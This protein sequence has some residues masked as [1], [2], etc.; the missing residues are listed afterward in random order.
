MPTMRLVASVNAVSNGTYVLTSDTDNMY[1]NVDSTTYGTVTHNRASTNNTYYFYLR[2][3]NFDDIPSDA[4]VSNWTVKIKA[5]A[6][7][8]TTSTSSSY[9]MSLCQGTTSIG[10]T[11]ADGRLSTTTTTFTFAEGSLT[12]DSV[13]GYGANFGI[14]VPL[15]RA[16]SNTADVVTIY[17]AE[18]E[19]TYT[20]PNPV[21]VSSILVSGNGTISPSGTTI[22]AEGDEYTLTITPT[23]KTEEVILTKDGVDISSQLT[24][25]YLPP[26]STTEVSKTATSF[27]TGFSGGTNMSFYT[28][29][30][31]S[32]NNFNYAVG[33]TA[34]SP[35][36]TSSGSG[37]WTYVKDN[38]SSTSNT[39]YAD[40][41]FDFSAI[42]ANAE[43]ASVTVRCYGAIEDSS[44]STSHADITLF[45]GNTQKGTMQKFTSSSNSIIT[46]SDPGTWTRAELQ[47]AK[48][49]FAVGYYGGHIFGITWIV[50]YYIPSGNPD[51]YTYTFEVGANDTVLEVTI[52]SAGPYIPPEEDPDKTYY[53]LT[54]SSINAT[55]DPPTGTTRVEAGTSETITIT[56]SD[57]QLTLA[58]DNGVDITNQLIGGVP[59]N[60][61]TV[62]TQVSGASYGFNLNSSTGYYVSTNNGVNKSASVARL[63]MDFESDCLVTI[64]YINYAEANYDYGLFG[65]LDTTVATDGLTASGSGSNPSDSTSNYQ[66]A[67][68]SNSAS[69][70]TITYQVPSGQHYIDIKYGKDDATDAN[71]DSLQW[72]VL[73]VEPT[74]GGGDYTYTLNN[75]NQKHSLIFIFGNV[76][77]Y[78]IT[79]STTSGAR[80]FPDG[81]QVVLEGDAYKINIV[82]DSVSAQVTMKDNNIDVT[83]QLVQESGTDKHGNPAVSYSYSLS[84]ITAAHNLVITIGGATIQIY[85]KENGTWVTYSKVY[86]K[87][88]G[89]WV[90]QDSS[91]WGTIFDVNA[92]YRKRN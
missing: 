21:N 90:E 66:L 62:T 11:Y 50:N 43:I 53:S 14:R 2:G 59:T 40:F 77:Y 36:S 31:S 34:E 39:G 13:A 28:S 71:N 72:K 47:S 46:I 60:T 23:D 57:P 52:G 91:T 55:T 8:H 38:G 86:K 15:R 10:N 19:V 24:E 29:S 74:S 25:H 88:N 16:N 56:P 22:M 17:G 58:L 45:S 68:C 1:T 73:S 63:N 3:F 87:I 67:M 44:Q 27:T 92:N 9:Q 83:S 89:S 41:S 18:I 80:I 26:S 75:I 6:K 78:F 69:A 51:Y 32:T 20:I 48:L 42:P 35:G 33:H 54:I 81:Q 7:G 64:Q 76:S 37:S 65:K 5:S 84:N 70:Q 61:Y 85:I 82:P 30:S 12:W 79:S 4:I 49:R